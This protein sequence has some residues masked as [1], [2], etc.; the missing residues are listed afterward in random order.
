[1]IMAFDV[2]QWLN[3]NSEGDVL[4]L[5]KGEVS[6]SLVADSLEKI[7]EKTSEVPSKVKK[8]IYNVFVECMQNL[9]HHS[10][11]IPEFGNGI[12]GKYAICILKQTKTNYQVIS[13]NF[14]GDKQRNFLEKH[15]THINS[16]DSGELKELYKEI[17]D[18]QEF[19]DKGGGGLGLV[20][21]SRKSGSKL[22]YKFSNHENGFF[23]FELL[24]NIDV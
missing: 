23:F 19:S 5:F 7:E 12:K 1:M 8:K 16:L 4:F 10:S 21:M 18:N 2:G 24:I 22:E 6:N 9:F 3:K 11:I 20:D 13:G 15:I 17:L 14:I